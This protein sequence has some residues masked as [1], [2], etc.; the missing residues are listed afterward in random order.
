[1][2]PDG[3]ISA[4]LGLA[5]ESKD[6]TEALL[7]GL[8][9]ANELAGRKKKTLAIIIDEFSDIEKYNG[10]TIEKA[11][12]SEI[13]KHQ[14]TSYIFSGSEQSIMLAMVRDKKRAFY[15]MGRIMS[16]G[17]IEPKAY[18]SFIQGWFEKGGYAISKE[19][20]H[21]FLQIG[22]NVTYNVQRLCHVAWEA[23]IE[24]KKIDSDVARELPFLIVRQDAPHYEILWQTISQV[25]QLLLIA[26]IR[27]PDAQP[28]SKD[29]QF[30]H[31]VGPSSSIKASLDSLVK[32]GVLYKTTQGRYQ[33]V[34]LFMPYW[35][36]EI[37]KLR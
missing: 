21:K 7:E 26:L 10:G 5:A 8:A 34:D 3:D 33:F 18:E 17:P 20:V 29:F 11:I 36:K 12:R 4:G 28:F 35:V 13:Q 25:Q 2:G 37:R 22:G 30:R 9:H 1:L 15:K 31:K 24:E 6:A 14:H 16:L 32:K 23:S 19:D 27:D